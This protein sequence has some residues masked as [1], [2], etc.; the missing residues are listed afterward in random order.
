[1]T[2][3]RPG[4][5]TFL[6]SI[7]DPF[8]GVSQIVSFLDVVSSKTN[9][10]GQSLHTIDLDNMILIEQ[11][12]R[13]NFW[14]LLGDVGGFYDGIGLMISSAIGPITFTQFIVDLFA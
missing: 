2:H 6:D 7:L 11:R 3:V 12:V 9:D 4:E 8:G 14:Q 5:A 1:M 10:I 13:Y